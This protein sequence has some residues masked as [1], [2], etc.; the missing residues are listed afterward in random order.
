MNFLPKSVP[1]VARLA[2]FSFRIRVEDT[3]D[4][5]QHSRLLTLD[6]LSTSYTSRFYR[7]LYSP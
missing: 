3:P 2:P 1:T 7:P 6:C 4:I 5:T